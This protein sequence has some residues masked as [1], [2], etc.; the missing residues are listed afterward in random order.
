MRSSGGNLPALLDLG[1]QAMDVHVN[2]PFVAREIETP[3][4]LQ[5]PVARERDARIARKLH[6]QGELARFELHVVAVN[7]G[8]PRR[9]VELQ[10][11]E[12]QRRRRLH[13][14]LPHAPQDRLNA[15]DQ[16]SRREGL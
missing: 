4:A 15:N 16:L 12:T 10:A 9:G 1:A 11:A 2:G 5:Q 8:F 14:G 6:Q 13:D 3:H 7:A